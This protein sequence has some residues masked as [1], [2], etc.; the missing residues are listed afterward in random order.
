MVRVSVST[1]R[2]EPRKL[3]NIEYGLLAGRRESTRVGAP[4]SRLKNNNVRPPSTIKVSVF[5]AGETAPFPVTFPV[6][7]RF[8][9]GKGARQ[10]IHLR[11]LQELEI[12]LDPFFDSLTASDP[13]GQFVLPDPPADALSTGPA[14][15]R[16]GDDNDS[17]PGN[18][19]AGDNEFDG[20]FRPVRLGFDVVRVGGELEIRNLQND[21]GATSFSGPHWTAVL[22]PDMSTGARQRIMLD[23]KP[24]WI[25]QVLSQPKPK[26]ILVDRET[27]RW[28]SYISSAGSA[29][30]QSQKENAFR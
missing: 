5:R 29:R 28:S 16:Y 30:R 11:A 22:H 24:D 27:R 2:T 20:L 14:G 19:G 4:L 10:P 7:R 17:R 12:S 1:A 25:R 3:L 6:T 23:W 21:E 26:S 13:L 15:P 18:C 9:G 8:K